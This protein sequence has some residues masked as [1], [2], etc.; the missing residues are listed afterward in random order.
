MDTHTVANIAELQD[1]EKQLHNDFSSLETQELKKESLEKMQQLTQTRIE[2]FNALKSQY[3]KDVAESKDELKDQMETLSIVENEL[4]E[5]KNRLARMQDEHTNK[6]RMAEF[7]T[8]FS[9]KY[10]SYNELLMLTLKWMVPIGLLLYIAN[11]NPIPENYL[12][13]NNS[14]NLF[15]VLITVVTLYA[16]YQILTAYYDISLRNNMNFNQYDFGSN[17]KTGVKKESSFSH[18]TKEFGKMAES[19]HLGCVD[20]Y[21]C[22]DGTLYDS[23]KRQC[24]PAIKTHN[25]N[26]KK[27]SLAKGAMG[28]P[29][30]MTDIEK[31]IHDV[32]G[33]SSINVPFSS[34]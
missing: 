11:R 32:E 29:S 27:A 10:K 26:N 14:N 2:L 15:L 25:E 34:V 23:V 6:M 20:S 30:I 16:L 28:T 24:I 33:F 31:N 18:D 9:L 12:S 1:R 21:C 8:Y 19:L 13:Q 7:A 3:A 22:A 17:I 4:G 5:A